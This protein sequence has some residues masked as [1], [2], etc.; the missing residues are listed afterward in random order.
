MKVFRSSRKL[1]NSIKGNSNS[2]GMVLTMGAIHDG[3][4]SLIK[5]ALS[6]N[7]SVLV[8]IFINPTQ[9]DDKK[10]LEK[11]PV[12]LSK[13]L[14]KV[15][16]FDKNIYVFT[17]SVKEVYG[18]NINSKNFDFKGLDLVMEGEKRKNHFNGVATVV[19]YFLETFSPTKAYFGEKD[20]QQLRIV[21]QLSELLNFPTK[22]IGCPIIRNSDGLAM[23]SRNSLLTNEEKKIA[24]NLYKILIMVKELSKKQNYE[25]IKAKVL[26][27]LN[28]VPKLKLEYFVIADNYSLKEF[29]PYQKI[30][31]GRAFIAAYVGK[32]RLI[33]NINLS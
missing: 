21:S 8:S 15:S 27:F 2:L 6:E 25:T 33:D 11:Y 28:K 9:F 23:S 16:Q 7:E 31:L 19:E 10:D 30:I 4:I 1:I 18:E 32:I 3:H 20:Y 22:I 26:L 13:D 5:R 14:K 12:S 24:I 29:K 17:P